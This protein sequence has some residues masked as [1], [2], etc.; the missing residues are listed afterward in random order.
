MK[1]PV[2]GMTLVGTLNKC[3]KCG[4]KLQE[5][6]RESQEK[7]AKLRELDMTALREQF[8]ATTGTGFEGYQIEQYLGIKNGDTLVEKFVST[9]PIADIIARSKETAV[10]ALI[11]N[12]ILAGANGVIGVDTDIDIFP[13]GVVFSATGTAVKIKKIN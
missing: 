7:A 1:C 11:G 12:C 13:F 2:C 6:Y 4:T 10:N 9:F 3:P 5:T 8:L